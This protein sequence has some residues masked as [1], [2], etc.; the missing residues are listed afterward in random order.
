[1]RPRRAPT[2]GGAPPTARKARTGEFTPPGKEA[3]GAL[4]ESLGTG[5]DAGFGPET[6]RGFSIEGE[7]VAH[8]AN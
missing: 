4:L 6:H 2:N 1:M 5:A 8:P 7:M 3:L